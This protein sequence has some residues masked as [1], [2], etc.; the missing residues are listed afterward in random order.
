MGSRN[1]TAA[2]A[3]VAGVVVLA[4][5]WLGGSLYATSRLEAELKAFAE[6]PSAETGLRV[7]D[8]RQQ[9]RFLGGTGTARVQLQMQP[10]QTPA[11]TPVEAALSYDISSFLLPTSLARVTWSL[12]PVAAPASAQNDA[13]TVQGQGVLTY[14]GGIDTAFAVSELQSPPAENQI[15]LPPSNGRLVV[16]P[17]RVVLDWAVDSLKVRVPGGQLDLNKLTV[18]VNTTDIERRLGSSSVSIDRIHAGGTQIDGLRY[19]AAMT[20]A[21]DRRDIR[22]SY[23]VRSATFQDLGAALS[24]LTLDLAVTGLDE[25]TMQRLLA[26]LVK[27][28]GVQNLEG[29][30]EAMF[31]ED[32]RTL[33]ARGFS[34]GIPRLSATL[35]DGS[36][37]GKL[38]IDLGASGNPSGLIPLEKAL[39]ASGELLAKG[40]M[41][42]PA[43][44]QIL[45]AS[46][47]AHEVPEALKAD[48]S[49][50]SG[51]LQ[52][53]GTPA[54]PE[55]VRKALA[56]ADLALGH[57]LATPLPLGPVA[58][59][60]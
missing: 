1:K 60:D 59:Q 38:A 31:R 53:N 9:S 54:D 4:A 17:P 3:G 34:V 43:Q 12:R 16:D 49:Y 36:L 55:E 47:F 20:V 30:E 50:E 39:H 40:Q 25:A 35:A 57:F 18:G 5:A 2:I 24:G 48:F 10:P 14:S 33:L 51:A 28:G 8:L 23:R 15:S 22:G 11:G 26:A 56:E 7:L 52:I 19:D 32:L 29:A 6:R 44:R 58:A 45:V 27:A 37:E 42:P 21:G 13:P 46:G 41:I